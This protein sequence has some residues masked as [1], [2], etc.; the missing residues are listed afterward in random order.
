MRKLLARI[1]EFFRRKKEKH[2]TLADFRG[3][4]KLR[5]FLGKT[6]YLND[7]PLGVIEKII[8]DRRS[9]KAKVVYV[10]KD[11]KVFSVKPKF[12]LVEKEI[13]KIKTA[14]KKSEKAK[15]R[16]VVERKKYADALSEVEKISKEI[17]ELKDKILKLDNKLIEDEI[18]VKTFKIVRR[19]L[20][21][22]I[23]ELATRGKIYLDSLK[24]YL[25]EI[26]KK[27]MLLEKE[28]EKYRI[29]LTLKEVGEEKVKGKLEALEEKIK[30]IGEEIEKVKNAIE[31]LEFYAGEYV[32]DELAIDEDILSKIFEK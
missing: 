30:E 1:L 8:A 16:K 14:R 26:Y 4:V 29:Q 13:L 31:T 10:R 2:V 3:V 9:K 15:E 6:I 18:D 5:K 23:R 17:E 27:K 11:G 20:E 19:D 7:E 32:R 22:K 21:A 28:L 24:S 12:I 25:R